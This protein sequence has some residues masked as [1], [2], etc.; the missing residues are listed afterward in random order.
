MVVELPTA[1]DRGEKRNSKGHMESW[2]GF[3]FHVDAADEQIPISCLLTS[4]SLHDSQASIPL[5]AMTYRRVTSLY[6]VK[7]SAYDC[8]HIADY[9]RK[10]GHVPIINPNNRKG[11]QQD[12]DPTKKGSIPRAVNGGTDIRPSERRIRRLYDQ[13]KGC[14]QSN[15]TPHVRYPCPHCRSSAPYDAI[16]KTPILLPKL[17]LPPFRKGYRKSMP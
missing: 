17:S 7:D 4:V 9:S 13:D 6:E 3:K 2:N 14:S 5:T 1:C 15:G 10:L 16:K 11:E 8:Q 12:L